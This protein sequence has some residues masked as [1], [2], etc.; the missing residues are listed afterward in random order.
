MNSINQ[1]TEPQSQLR[2]DAAG[3]GGCGVRVM[4]GGGWGYSA[5]K[6]KAIV[7]IDILLVFRQGGYVARPANWALCQVLYSSNHCDPSL[8]LAQS[9]SVWL[10]PRWQPLCSEE[11]KGNSWCQI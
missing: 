3:V 7:Q 4:C 6:P 8:S 10:R 11:G 9:G 5:N 2:V 1:S